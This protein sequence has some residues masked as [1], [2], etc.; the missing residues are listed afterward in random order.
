MT[1][2]S[3][4]TTD[5]LA[6]IVGT[7]ETSERREK[8]R[9]AAIEELLKPDVVGFVVFVERPSGTQELLHSSGVYLA[10]AA[11]HLLTRAGGR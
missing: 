2:K 10:W 8:L 4:E 3:Q 5:V 11:A 9:Q 7:S 1:N 6:E